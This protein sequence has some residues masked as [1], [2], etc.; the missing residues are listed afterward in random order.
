MQLCIIQIRR[1][2]YVTTSYAVLSYAT[3][4]YIALH[5]ITKLTDCITD[6]D[7]TG[8]FRW[9]VQL[10]LNLEAFVSHLRYAGLVLL[11]EGF[12][13]T[14]KVIGAEAC[15]LQNEDYTAS[16]Q[17]YITTHYKHST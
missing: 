2:G 12:A 5:H 13:P 3:L 10:D 6:A 11:Q 1:Y 9:G 8:E 16:R 14:L 15:R 17:N 7:K 4:Q